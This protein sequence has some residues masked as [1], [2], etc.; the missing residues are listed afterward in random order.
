M[1]AAR[2]SLIGRILARGPAAARRPSARGPSGPGRALRRFRV[3]FQTTTTLLFIALTVLTI[4]AVIGQLPVT[5]FLRLDPLA[6]L[7]TALASRTLA[8]DLALALAV[9]LLTLVF[10]RVFCSFFCPLGGLNTLLTR[11]FGPQRRPLG[12]PRHANAWRPAHALKYALQLGLLVAALF[13]VNL[14]GVVD[15]LPFTARSFAAAIRPAALDVWPVWPGGGYSL[16]WLLGALFL[17]VLGLNALVPRWFCRVLCPLGALLG[18]LSRVSLW[19]IQRDPA[20]CTDCGRCQAVCPVAAEPQGQLR[21]AECVTCFQCT[22]VCPEAALNYRFLGST[23][24]TTPRVDIGR[25]RAAIALVTGAAAVPLLRAGAEAPGPAGLRRDE[26][27]L[28]RPPGA[29]AEPAFLAACIRC[30]A[31]IAAC[32]TRVL[33]IAW[34]QGGA[35]GLWTP[36]LNFRLGHCLPEC[37]ACGRV[38]PTGAIQRFS[39]ADRRPG[40]GGSPAALRSGTA[41]F[42]PGHCLPWAAGRPC[43]KC[44]EHCPTSPKAIWLEPRSVSARDGRAAELRLPHIDL[45]RCIGCGTCEWVCPVRPAGVRVSNAGESRS[46]SKQLLMLPPGGP[47]RPG[48]A[49]QPAV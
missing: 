17:L 24:T 33:D 3:V 45:E 34:L 11:L 12:E 42:D 22:A 23:A 4:E 13:G 14:T 38:C 49:G 40:P 28:L 44:E 30:G 46:P 39:L 16:A 36:V 18:V 15:P 41:F 5:V 35:A 1:K 32:P 29:L 25:R 10:G 26:P 37:N 31:C 43:A 8:A 21:V 19:R 6:A 7:G 27:T 48:Q 47:A 9:V 2:G 20:R